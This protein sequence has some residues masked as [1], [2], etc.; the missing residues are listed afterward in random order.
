MIGNSMNSQNDLI[1]QRFITMKDIVDITGLTD[2]WFYKKI[3]EG[4]FP[5]PIKFGR[6]SRWLLED[7]NIWLNRKIKKSRESF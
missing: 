7:I 2:K 3:Q 4:Q 6:S 1:K 5:P